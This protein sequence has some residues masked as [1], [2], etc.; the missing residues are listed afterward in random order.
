VETLAGI[1]VPRIRGDLVEVD[2]GE[3]QLEGRKVPVD[4]DGAVKDHPVNVGEGSIKVTC[5]SM[6]NPH[7]VV[8][9]DDA[10]SYPVAEVGPKVE[11]HPFFPRGVNVEFVQVL[12]PNRLRLR[13]WERGAGMTPACGSGAC[14]AAVAAHWTGRAEREAD[15]ELV[16]GVLHI[17][18]DR[19][20]SRVFMTGPATA[21]FEGEFFL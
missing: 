6:G 11:T 1:V 4:A 21:V 9:V 13:V 10:A 8:F 2:M 14:A 19:E 3:P 12:A 18:W 17:R 16:G 5:V 20:S 7:A 15:V